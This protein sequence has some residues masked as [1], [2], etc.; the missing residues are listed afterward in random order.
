DERDSNI[1]VLPHV[2][3]QGN[4]VYEF[5]PALS[6][7]TGVPTPAPRAELTTVELNYGTSKQFE[8]AIAAQQTG[9]QGETLWYRLVAGGNITRYVRLR[10]RANLAAVLDEHAD[11][12]LPERANAFVAHMTVEI[13]TLRPSML[14]GV[15]PEPQ[16]R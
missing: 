6:K 7:G 4:G 8:A 5:L 2:E 15:T 14:V 11:Q 3:F 9:L 16:G 12:A 13:L 1:N 10:P